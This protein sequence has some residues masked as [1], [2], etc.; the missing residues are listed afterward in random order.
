MIVMSY[1]SQHKTLSYATCSL[2]DSEAF[3][4]EKI[5]EWVALGHNQAWQQTCSY[6]LDE[7]FHVSDVCHSCV[8]LL[9]VSN[10]CSQNFSLVC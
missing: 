5:E 1:A 2:K 10:N 7:R 8:T 6:H 4:E 9:M 3:V